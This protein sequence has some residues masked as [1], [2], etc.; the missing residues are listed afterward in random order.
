MTV[1]TLEVGRQKLVLMPESEYKRLLADDHRSTRDAVEFA[2][3]AIG[4]DLRRKREALKMNQQEVAQKADI[5]IETLSR[6]ESGRANP[7][8]GTVKKILKALGEKI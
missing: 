1:Q 2:N 8:I 5:R 6:I 4:R 3:E 7:T